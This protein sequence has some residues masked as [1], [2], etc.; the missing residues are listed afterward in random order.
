MQA[1]FAS[2]WGKD[3]GG[4]CSIDELKTFQFVWKQIINITWGKDE[5]GGCSTDKVKTLQ[6]VWK[7][8]IS[9][10]HSPLIKNVELCLMYQSFSSCKG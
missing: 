7:Q 8:T 10:P 9:T 6:F 4:G 5:G 1:S 2:A 3:E